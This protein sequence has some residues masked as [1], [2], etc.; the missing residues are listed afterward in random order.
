MPPN[1]PNRGGFRLGRNPRPDE[2]RA[3]R[4]KHGLSQR[5]AADLIYGSTRTFQ[6]YEAPIGSPDHRRM[7]PAAWELMLL[8]LEEITLYDLIKTWRGE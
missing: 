4:D 2:I 6:S 5:S 8:K 3:L 1:H 7:H